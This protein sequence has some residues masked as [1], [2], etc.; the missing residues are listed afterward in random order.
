MNAENFPEAYVIVVEG[1]RESARY[2]LQSSTTIGRAPECDLVLGSTHVS[3]RHAEIAWDGERFVL[4]DLDSLNGTRIGGAAILEPHSLA[5][6]ETIELAD[7]TLRFEVADAAET[8]LFFPDRAVLAVDEATH[9]VRL[10]GRLLDLT[11]KEFVLLA[12]LDERRPAVVEY[13]EIAARVWPELEG[14]VS[15]DNIAQLAARLRR[16]LGGGFIA[17]VRGFGYRLDTPEQQ[18]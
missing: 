14:A 13:G 16:K 9:E 18:A 3:R 12:L 8:Q 11:P 6:G 1:G 15:E 2:R 7:C 17:N 10:D 5:S 4:T